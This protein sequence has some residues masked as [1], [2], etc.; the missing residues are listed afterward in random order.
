MKAPPTYTFGVL[1]TIKRGIGM[2]ELLQKHVSTEPLPPALTTE[3]AL[4]ISAKRRT[5]VELVERVGPDH[6]RFQRG[7]HLQ[8]ARSLVCPHPSR[9]SISRVIR[10]LDRFRERAKRQHA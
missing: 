6:T 2:K 10:F 7:G 5:R 9:Q 4:L 8:D 1:V 3:A